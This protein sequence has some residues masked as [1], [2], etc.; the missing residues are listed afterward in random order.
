MYFHRKHLLAHSSSAPPRIGLSAPET[1]Q[2]KQDWSKW[3]LTWWDEARILCLE[4]WKWKARPL[5]LPALTERCP[6]E[7]FS[8]PES[9]ESACCLCTQTLYTSTEGQKVTC[10]RQPDFTHLPSKKEVSL[11]EVSLGYLPKEESTPEPSSPLAHSNHW[12]FC[13]FSQN[14]P[15]SLVSVDYIHDNDTH[16]KNFWEIL[17]T[18]WQPLTPQSLAPSP[19]MPTK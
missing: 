2:G 16:C 5:M 12:I 9:K 4:F 18:H 6:R 8:K 14:L 13:S 7:P 3:L 1:P 17:A 11:V 10:D 15:K 19:H